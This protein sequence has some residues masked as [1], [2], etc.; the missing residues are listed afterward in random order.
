MFFIKKIIFFKAIVTEFSLVERFKGSLLSSL[1]FLSFFSHFSH[2]AIANETNAPAPPAPHLLEQLFPFLLVAL[3]FYFLLI[4]PQQR[5]QKEQT[6]FLLRLQE[7][8]EVLTTGGIYGKIVRIMGE[9]ILLEVSENTQIR[10]L[11]NCVSAYAQQKNPEKKA[12]T[13]NKKAKRIKA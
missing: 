12:P 2:Q 11:K 7:G 4:R 10:L 3:F 5:R 6:D 13:E 8:D 9:Y 1:V